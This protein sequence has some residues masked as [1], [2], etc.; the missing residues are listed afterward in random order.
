MVSLVRSRPLPKKTIC[1]K[2]LKIHF[3]DYTLCNILELYPVEKGEV[4]AGRES[5]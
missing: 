4:P 2:V 3:Q 1:C 5:G